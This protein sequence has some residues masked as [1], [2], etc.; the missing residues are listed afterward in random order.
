M[1]R[2]GSIVFLPNV[3][4]KLPQRFCRRHANLGLNARDAFLQWNRAL[5]RFER[6]ELHH[7]PPQREGGLFDVVPLW[8]SE[9]ARVDP[10]RHL[11]G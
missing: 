7:N 2:L 11:G 8:P 3:G 1:A 10:L 6:M 4:Q 9:H 5:G